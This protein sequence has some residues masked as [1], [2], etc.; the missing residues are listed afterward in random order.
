MCIRNVF[1]T[2]VDA[3]ELPSEVDEGRELVDAVLFSV[4]MVVHL[5]EGDV[6]RVGL[7]ELISQKYISQL[8]QKATPF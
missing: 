8:F 6:Q 1:F 3:W 7:L 5:H 4:A 2:S